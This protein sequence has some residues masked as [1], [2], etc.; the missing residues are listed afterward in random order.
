MDFSTTTDG[1]TSHIVVS[2]RLDHLVAPQLESE[3]DDLH[4]ADRVHIVVDLA[5]IS[6]LDSAGLAVLAK[7][8][9]LQ[10]S[11]DRNLS[12]VLPV[13]DAPR[14]VFE[15][16]GFGEVFDIMEPNAGSGVA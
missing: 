2:G 15:L 13:G 16:T 12:V 7:Y 9:R 1:N 4:M 3:L 5:A 8:R 11:D 14:R 10:Q 6:F